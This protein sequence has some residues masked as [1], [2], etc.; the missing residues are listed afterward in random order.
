M[1]FDINNYLRQ[2]EAQFSGADGDDFDFGFDEFFIEL[3]ENLFVDEQTRIKI[4][5]IM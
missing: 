1:K 2:S 3:D 4:L 5:F